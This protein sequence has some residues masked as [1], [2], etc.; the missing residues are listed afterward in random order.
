MAE[1]HLDVPGADDMTP[2]AALLAGAVARSR[3]LPDDPK[4]STPARKSASPIKV[5]TYTC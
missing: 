2:G 5:T 1:W 4:R 3:D